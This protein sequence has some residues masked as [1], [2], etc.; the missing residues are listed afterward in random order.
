M[1]ENVIS[2]IKKNFNQLEEDLSI[3]NKTSKIKNE[4]E[5]E[6]KIYYQKK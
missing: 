2:S 4:N 5:F 1:I 3:Y 6:K